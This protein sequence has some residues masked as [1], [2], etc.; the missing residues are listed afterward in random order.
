MAYPAYDANYN[1]VAFPMS[2]RQSMAYQDGYAYDPAIN[3]GVYGE[4]SSF[5]VAR[6]ASLTYVQL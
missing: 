5:S 4:V 2:R 6:E 1:Q 3:A